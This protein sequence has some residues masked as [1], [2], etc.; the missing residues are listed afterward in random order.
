MRTHVEINGFLWF[1]EAVWSYE[2][3]V[4]GIHYCIRR[5]MYT[6][7]KL[8]TMRTSDTIGATSLS[9]HEKGAYPIF[10]DFTSSKHEKINF[11]DSL[12]FVLYFCNP[13]LPISWYH[14]LLCFTACLLKNA[15]SNVV[16]F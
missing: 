14:L 6:L 12:H 5:T 16:C 11:G 2:H 15:F 10:S 7:A 13:H 4:S 9:S 1:S 8:R 3:T